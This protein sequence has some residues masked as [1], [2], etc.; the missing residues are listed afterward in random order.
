MY[1][2]HYLIRHITPILLPYDPDIILYYTPYYVY[3][4]PV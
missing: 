1:I 3:M 2:F 4:I